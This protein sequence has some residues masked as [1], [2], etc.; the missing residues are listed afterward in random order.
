[1]ILEPDQRNV[2]TLVNLACTATHLGKREEA[3]G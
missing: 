1:M 2:A 3:L